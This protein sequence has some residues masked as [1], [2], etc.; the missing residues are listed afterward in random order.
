[1][2]GRG[3]GVEFEILAEHAEQMFLQAHHERMDPGIE[4]TFAPS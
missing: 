1:M 2:R 3:L 4:E